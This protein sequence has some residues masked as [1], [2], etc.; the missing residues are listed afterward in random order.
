MDSI[1]SKT[2][3]DD[4]DQV[5]VSEVLG[6]HTTVFELKVAKGDIGKTIGKRGRTADAMRSVLH[7]SLGSPTTW[8]AVWRPITPARGPNTLG[9]AD[10]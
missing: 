6:S 3:V 8:I 5:S 1:H 9:P 10:R 2:L 7:S 4:A